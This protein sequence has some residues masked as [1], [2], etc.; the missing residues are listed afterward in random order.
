M[1]AR[2]I[3]LI[4]QDTSIEEVLHVCLRYLAGWDVVSVEVAQA[5]LEPDINDRLDAI[6]VDALSPQAY[7]L[8]FIQKLFIQK[9]KK[10]RNTQ[11]VPILLLTDKA[12]WFTAEQLHAL[13]IEGA[14]GKPFD[15][16]TL[17]TQI[18]NLLRWD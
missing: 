9:L 14:I 17:P 3:L 8:G 11:S 1:S 6:L 7:G 4:H 13:G 10:N 2:R 12:D 5:N 15:P 18:A 16:V